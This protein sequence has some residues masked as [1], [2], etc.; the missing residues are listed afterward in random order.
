MALPCAFVLHLA[1]P[2]ANLPWL[3][4]LALAGL[5]AAWMTLAP[6]AAAA[7]GYLAGIVFFAFDFSW[8]GQ[9]AG[10][11]VGPF[12]F[13]LDLAPALV[14]ALA[15]AL[16]AALTAQAARSLRGFGVPVVAAAG[17][18]LAEL[19]RSSG[20]LGVPLYQVGA[21]FVDTPLAPLAAYAG[22]YG[23]TFAVALLGAALGSVAIEPDRRRAVGRLTAV[24]AGIAAAAGLAWLAWPA[25]TIE[26]ATIRVAAVQ[27]NI[28]Q[29]V[30]WRPES[31]P[32]AVAQYTTL[33]AGLRSF[34]PRFVLWPE[35]V[36]TTALLLDPALAAVPENAGLVAE[37]RALRSRFAALA[38]SL[39][40]VIAVGTDEASV[41]ADYNDLIFF[42]PA[43][44]S[45][46]VYRK[47][48]LVPFAEF[49]PG[50]EWLRS[51]PFAV[52]V[53]RFGSGRD[54][55]PEVG[56]LGAGPLIC[57][58]AG[59]TDLAQAEVAAGAKF[60]AVATDDAWFGDSD[61]PY[62]QAQL[63]SLRAVET[64]RWV[65]RAAATGVSGIVAPDG[66]WQVRSRLDTPAVLTGAIGAPQPTV[67]S[68]LGP[69]PVGA[70]L[71]VVVAVA[72]VPAGRRRRR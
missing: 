45:Q 40:A 54:L 50:P 12:A 66:R 57:W 32:F 29:S 38:R 26:P 16:A 43:D 52:L 69:W 21:P 64:G 9:T 18:T 15:F 5:F 20:L 25:R 59:F 72:F 33:T 46:R 4:P 10:S 19:L 67:Y 30:K 23:L 24:A 34:H 8:F 63:A 31:L 47:R 53:S 71:A 17:F 6:R 1:F 27:G 44:G 41:N 65:V 36:I 42:D 58:E 68:R 13:L 51:L 11:L 60:F 28:T 22:I 70:G 2:R 37:G 48:Q 3:A 56:Q 7:V 39:G 55:G 62:A 35:T 49:L 61:G 14:E